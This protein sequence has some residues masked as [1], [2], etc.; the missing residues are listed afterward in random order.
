MS[1]RPATTLYTPISENNGN[2]EKAE[3]RDVAS[4]RKENSKTGLLYCY[5]HETPIN[6]E[7]PTSAPVKEQGQN[8]FVGKN[9]I[10]SIVKTGGN[11]LREQPLS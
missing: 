5:I 3:I 2:S 11:S 4:L 6:M 7:Q 8:Q 10:I 9:K 1:V